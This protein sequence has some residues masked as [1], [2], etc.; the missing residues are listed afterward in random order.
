MPKQN[1]TARAPTL[2][3]SPAGKQS[4]GL[5]S[6]TWRSNKQNIILSSTGDFSQNAMKG[7]S[8]RSSLEFLVL[9]TTSLQLP[10]SSN[11][12]AIKAG[13]FVNCH[14]LSLHKKRHIHHVPERGTSNPQKIEQVIQKKK[15]KKQNFSP[16]YFS[17]YVSATIT[18]TAHLVLK[19]DSQDRLLA[20]PLS[21]F[22]HLW[23]LEAPHHALGCKSF[24]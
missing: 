21:V 3:C 4:S 9:E 23:E 22:S 2:P 17:L 11:Y 18:F 5:A 12:K 7:I 20:P 8:E 13:S 15:T 16:L 14:A 24:K 6:F 19:Q 10:N 1:P